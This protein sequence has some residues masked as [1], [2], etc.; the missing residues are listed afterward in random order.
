MTVDEIKK[1]FN[2]L[3][4][5]NVFDKSSLLNLQNKLRDSL[6]LSRLS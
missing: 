1:N 4:N 5:G 6:K 3:I 2:D